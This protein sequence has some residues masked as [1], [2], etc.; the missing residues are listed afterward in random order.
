[1][2]ITTKVGLFALAGLG[3]ALVIRTRQRRS[4]WIDFRERVV[5]ITGGSRGLG[6]VIARALAQEGALLALLARDPA[7]LERAKEELIEQ[8]AE[9]LVIS[10]DVR[11]QAEVQ[12]AIE[13]IMAH[14]GRLDVLINNAGVIQVGPIE[15]MTVE[16][17][18]NALA[19][20]TWGPLYTMLAAIPYMRQQGGG[21]I[22]N[23][24]SIGGKV[25]VP[26]LLPYSTSK[27]ALVGLSDGMRAELAQDRIYV[28]TVCPGLM[29]TGSHMNAQFKGQHQAEFTWFSI[30]DALPVSSTSAENAARQIIEACRHGDPNLVITIQA[31][32]ATL[33]NELAP[34]LVAT[35]MTI[36]N[37]FLPQPTMEQG[38]QLKSGWE[39]QSEWAPSLLTRLADK[40]TTANNELRGHAPI[41]EP[42]ESNGASYQKSKFSHILTEDKL[43]A[44]QVTKSIIVQGNITNIYNLWANFEN[45]PHFMKNIVSVTKTGPDTSHWVM[46]GPLGKNIEWDAKTTRMEENK[47]IA[48]NSMEREGDITTSGQVTFNAL[49]Q[50]QVEVMATIHYV[51]SSKL[52]EIG[53]ALF[54]DP[55]KQLAEDLQNFK[56]YAEAGITVQA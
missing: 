19:V 3:A 26:H 28:T 8:G 54:A 5:V 32:L 24:S 1:M 22:V 16:D 18:E 55:E 17:F 14:Y 23:V 56:R 2:K 47:R 38:D 36:F 29:R 40:A 45:F 25:S 44:D 31:R 46:K 4:R 12:E 43:M 52:A 30:F 27:F 37:G 39:S 15:H 48:W 34:R 13:Q 6:L 53:A 42:A 9:V 11:N 33:V 7:E 20:H 21:R 10:C 51:P 35:G 41:V 50:G 49:P